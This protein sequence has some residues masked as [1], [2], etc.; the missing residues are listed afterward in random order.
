MLT[1]VY[2]KDAAQVIEA[3]IGT[4]L[5]TLINQETDAHAVLIGG[6]HG[7]WLPIDI[8]GTLEGTNNMQD[9]LSSAAGLIVSRKISKYAAVYAEPIY[10]FNTNP[11][12]PENGSDN[13]T[14][15]IGLGGRLRIRPSVY[16]VGEVTP[17]AE[18][19]A[20]GA[21]LINV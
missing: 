6:F 12:V 8:I 18:V 20:L 14:M 1:T 19:Y 11:T 3:E 13:N 2:T 5:R 4:P 7:A 10:I 9:K 15:M 16:V 17:R 21:Q